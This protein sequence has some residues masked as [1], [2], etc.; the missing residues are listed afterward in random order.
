M[1]NENKPID[2]LVFELQE[3]AKELNCLYTIEDS[4]NRSDI[5]L[6]QAFHTV[7][8]AIPPGWQYPNICKAKL[9][10]GDIVYQTSDFDETKWFIKS[11]IIVQEKVVGHIAVYYLEEA[12]VS[13]VGPFLK[14]ERKLLD[15]IAERLG[16]FILHQKLKNVFNELKTVREQVDGKRKGEWRIVLDMIRKTDPNLFMSLLRKILHLLCWK[17]VE[18]AEMLMKHTSL[19]RRGSEEDQNLDDNK[20]LKVV[21]IVN[22]DQYV[23]SIIKLADENLPD[24]IIL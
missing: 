21:K 14:E 4:L 18:E 23:E 13:D 8:N 6:R 17:G 7:I 3:R 5:S 20:P 9:V 24:D 19:S 16:H 11:D 22:Y 2:N 1:V 10:Y 12:P 15:T